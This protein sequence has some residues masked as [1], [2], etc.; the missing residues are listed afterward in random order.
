MFKRAS[1]TR[2]QC[3]TLLYFRFYSGC[4]TLPG[5]RQAWNIRRKKINASKIVKLGI[6]EELWE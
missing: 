3:P 5:E 2:K 6:G 1:F 4:L